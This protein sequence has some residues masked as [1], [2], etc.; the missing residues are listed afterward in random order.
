ML[1]MQITDMIAMVLRLCK[2]SLC[3]VW[4]ANDD[5]WEDDGTWVKVMARLEESSSGYVLGLRI[6]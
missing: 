6:P 2:V 4:R 1:S 3:L 5:W